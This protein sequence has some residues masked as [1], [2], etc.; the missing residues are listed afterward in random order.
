MRNVVPDC[1]PSGIFQRLLAF[2][3]RHLDLR[4]QRGLGKR[5]RNHAVKVVALAREEGVLFHVKNHVEIAGWAAKCSGLAI[6]A[7]PD[8]RSVLD[9]GRHFRLHRPLTQHAPFAFALGAGIRNHT[10][11][12]LARRAGSSHRE[13]SLLITYLP[14]ALAGPARHRGLSRRSARAGTVF[15][16]LVPAHIDFGLCA[17]DGFLKLQREVFPEVGTALSPRSPPSSTATEHLSDAEEL[18]EDIAQILK[19]T[20][21]KSAA[22]RR[23]HARMTKP[24]V[25]GAFVGIDQDCVGLRHLSKL[26]FRIRIVRIPVR[27]VLHRQLAVRAFNL[28]LSALALYTQYFVVV[29]FDITRQNDFPPAGKETI[30]FS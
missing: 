25:G 9:S 19:C 6:S 1:V 17:E 27:M 18:A 5:N 14:S 23:R 4:S 24:I 3:G 7:E 28:L 16:S 2:Q 11:Y 26:V 13:K 20:R 22:G 21:I 8:A 12:P 30:L 29:A 10:A 15:A